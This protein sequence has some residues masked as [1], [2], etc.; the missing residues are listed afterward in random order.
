ML[1]T[2][3]VLKLVLNSKSGGVLKVKT[4]SGVISIT[5]PEIVNVT[6][7]PSGSVAVTLPMKV[8]FSSTVNVSDD[9]KTGGLIS[10]SRPCCPSDLEHENLGAFILPTPP[11]LLHVLEGGIQIL[12]CFVLTLHICP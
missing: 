8:S 9:V 2:T 3:L 5:S 4:P 6:G 11:A 12:F 1:T 10:L 7:F